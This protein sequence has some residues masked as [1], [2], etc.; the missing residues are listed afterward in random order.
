MGFPPGVHLAIAALALAVPAVLI[1][2]HWH[3]ILGGLT[4]GEHL[5]A[6]V[7]APEFVVFVVDGV[8]SRFFCWSLGWLRLVRLVVLPLLH[9]HLVHHLH[10]VLHH[11][12]HLSHH[13]VLIVILCCRLILTH[14]SIHLTHHRVHLAHHWILGHHRILGHHS[15]R[16]LTHHHVVG[17]HAGDGRLRGAVIRPVAS[18]SFGLS[19][20]FPVSGGVAGFGG[21][22]GFKC[23]LVLVIF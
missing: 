11:G 19:E 23:G 20:P 8:F 7:E 17:S 6:H 3:G 2:V 22:P 10:L 21:V 5:E 9:D 4:L 15:H 18:E 14:H 16:V 13:A 1:G 12:H